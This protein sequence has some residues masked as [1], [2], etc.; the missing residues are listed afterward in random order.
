MLALAQ[1]RGLPDNVTFAKLDAFNLPDDVLGKFTAV[2]AGFWWSHVKR[3]DQDK[4]LKQLRN[5]LGKDILLVLIDNSYVDGSSTVIART[6]LLGNTHQF[7]TTEAGE[8]YEV[9][10]NFPS[11]SHLRKKFAHSAREIRMKRLEYY[12]LLSCRLK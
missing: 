8:R 12:W 7:R 10:K 4:Y 2:F 11:D 9:L 6:D 5:K 1:A 3:E